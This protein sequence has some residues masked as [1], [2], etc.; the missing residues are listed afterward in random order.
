MSKAQPRLRHKLVEQMHLD[1]PSELHD[2][3]EYINRAQRATDQISAILEAFSDSTDQQTT[4]TFNLAD[5]ISAVITRLRPLARRSNVSLLHEPR[6]TAISS[7]PARMGQVVENLVLNAIQHIEGKS[8][9]KAAVAVSCGFSGPDNDTVW[10]RVADNGPGIRSRVKA[11]M[12]K[13]G[14][15]TK[16]MGLGVGLALCRNTMRELGGDVCVEKSVLFEG[17]S[18]LVTVPKSR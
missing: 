4:Q 8:L 15:T 11:H 9:G 18:M 3:G 5:I 17:T 14:F 7:S 13:M 16:P 6:P 1:P 10:V 12:F 2:L